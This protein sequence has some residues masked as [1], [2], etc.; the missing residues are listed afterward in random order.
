MPG[1]P[2]QSSSLPQ[3]GDYRLVELISE[4]T[5]TRTYHA[6]QISMDRVVLLE[7]IKEGIEV[8]PALVE[9][10]LA[11][12]RAKAA[13][14]HPGIGSVYEG[15]HDDE[16]V[17]Y[18]R[19]LLPGDDLE[20]LHNEGRTFSP[21]NVAALL[22]QVASA[23]DYYAERDVATLAL[24]PRHLVLGE[25]NVLRMANLAVAEP[26]DAIQEGHDRFLMGELFLDLLERG[27]PGATRTSK[28][29]TMMTGEDGT[30]LS[31][32]QVAHTARKLEEELS[33]GAKVASLAQAGKK[34]S[35]GGYLKTVVGVLA[36][37]LLVGALGAGGF[38]LTNRKPRPKARDLSAM[39]EIPAG[40]YQVPGAKP[41]QLNR[42][43]IDAHEVSIDEYAEFLRVLASLPMSKRSAYDD[44]NQPAIKLDHEPDEWESMLN[45]ARA[46]RPLD[47]LA[48][49]PNY[50]V[51]RIDWWD[52]QA[53]ANWK[54][55]RLPT[56]EEWFAAAGDGN[57]EPSERGAVDELRGDVTPRGV[58]GLAGNVSEWIFEPTRNPAFPMNPKSPL[59]CGASFLSPRNGVQARTWLPSREIRRRDLG[60]RV[61][62]D[63]A[64]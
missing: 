30:H 57:P 4:G 12:V 59:C 60:F 13:V 58:H 15:V 34:T 41:V 10:F 27:S 28:L 20:E 2:E 51:T 29:L 21:A 19:E 46:G 7:R 17:Y 40:T 36:I 33:E 16:V 48:H 53:Y 35:S 62:R 22:R 44:P 50:A 8:D 45:A 64:P 55:G 31:W 52:A 11:D 42:F 6:E 63:A 47:R 23:M 26:A 39:V 14:D 18:T 37:V 61:V 24:E 49:D 3:L 1:S 43:W 38:F 9:N 32:K 25:H 56:Q 5:V 54:G